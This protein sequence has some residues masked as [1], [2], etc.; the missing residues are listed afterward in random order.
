MTP[1][2]GTTTGLFTLDGGRR[3]LV[4]G[5][6]INHISSV[7]QSWWAVDGK[8]LVHRDGQVVA[9]MP[10]GITPLCV[11]PSRSTAWIGTNGAGLYELEGTKLAEDE[12]FADAPGREAWYTPWGAPPD[13]RS[14]A[15][16]ADH[17]LYVNVHVGGVL[18]YDDTG[19]VPVVDIE[20]DVQQLAAHPTRKGS[21]YAASADGLAISHNGHDFEFFAE[22]LHAHYS[23]A[24]AVFDETVVM[25]AS[26]GP[27]TSHGRLYATSIDG[28]PFRPL[29][30]GLPEWF[31][32]NLD[33]HCLLADEGSVYAGFDDTI[34]QSDDG[35]ERW[36]E[37]ASGL[38]RITC[39]G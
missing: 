3:R 7:G 27:Q 13:V 6:R 25:S 24:V 23:R 22:G 37:L 1:L 32:G 38:P 21:I 20:A 30:K 16:D 9:T 18:R 34:W 4:E 17:T 11:Q 28:G 31:D 15:L 5:T 10:E 8:G 14:M 26:T 12:F 35:G 33:T 29:A 2:I 39:L 19:L 36:T